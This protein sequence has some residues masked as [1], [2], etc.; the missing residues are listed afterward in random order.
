MKDLEHLK[1]GDKLV[2][3][4]GHN[5]DNASSGDYPGSVIP[6]SSDEPNLGCQTGRPGLVWQ[7]IQ[8]PLTNHN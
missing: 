4:T 1:A 8:E 2:L 7:M 3:N 5:N 6:E